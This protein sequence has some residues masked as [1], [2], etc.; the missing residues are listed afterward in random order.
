MNPAN[1]HFIR[2]V[3]YD[4][5]HSNRVGVNLFD[6]P[7]VPEGRVLTYRKSREVCVKTDRVHFQL[8]YKISW[9]LKQ[10]RQNT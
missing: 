6:D 7:K 5:N 9:D 8:F 2:L 10:L 4:P 3:I 1:S